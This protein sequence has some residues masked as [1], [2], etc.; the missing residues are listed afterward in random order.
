MTNWLRRGLVLLALASVTGLTW[1]LQDRSESVA[2]PRD[3][4]ARQW[5]DYSMESFAVTEF[6]PNG[7]AQYRLT[8]R[9]MDHFAADGTARFD[10]PNIVFHSAA[11]TPWTLTADAG[12]ATANSEEIRLNGAVVIE[13]PQTIERDWLRL[14][15]SNVLVRPREEFAET[16]EHVDVQDPLST[17]AAQGMR[18]YVNEERVMLLSKVQGKYET[19]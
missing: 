17:T 8:A 12:V 11:R 16:A 2:P 10:R 4:D 9:Q 19:R 13:R 18:V 14:S 15:T 1:W 3:P 7:D 5:P 6:L